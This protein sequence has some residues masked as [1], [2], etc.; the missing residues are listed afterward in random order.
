MS[1]AVEMWRKTRDS[2]YIALGLSFMTPTIITLGHY[3][4]AKAV[5]RES[6]ALCEKVKSLW[7]LGTAYRYLGSVSLA[8]GEFAEAQ[9]HFQESREVFGKYTEGWDVA[10]SLCYLGE[11]ARMEGHRTGAREN[12]LEALR[13][14]SGANSIPIAIDC[15]LGLAQLYSQD[16]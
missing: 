10:L 12:Y 7:G 3:D 4:E 8:E 1:V 13:V 16:G 14:S 15:L 5:L 6:I 11:S 9:A 2:H